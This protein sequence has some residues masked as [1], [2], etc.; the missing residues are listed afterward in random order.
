MGR[1]A[2]ARN[3]KSTK[4]VA[5]TAAMV[6][7]ATATGFAAGNNFKVSGGDGGGAKLECPRGMARLGQKF[8]VDASVF[9]GDPVPQITIVAT[10]AAD[11]FLV[12]K[13]NTGVHTGTHLDS[14]G[15][16]IEGGRTVD[17]LAAEEFVW[18]AYVVDVKARMAAVA[19]D[20]FQLS[21]ADI[22][23]YEKANGK[24]K[25]GSMVI[26]RTGFD[27]FY[28]TPAFLNDT[29]GFSAAAV[30][31]MVDNRN[32]GGVGSDTF[33]PDA[34]TDSTFGA[35]YTILNNNRVA[36]PGLNNL[37]ALQVKGDIMMAPTVA[38]KNGSGYQTDP[39][40]CLG[41]TNDGA[42]NHDGNDD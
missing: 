8:S 3:A 36:I 12:E 26:I 31:W 25:P 22:K 11:G 5:M 33:G 17:Q 14:P 1:I 42:S 2:R 23:A 7:I 19:D 20:G 29:P 10:I 40:A 16:F 34:S 27:K 21:V 39:L 35:T 24:I 32:I 41:R 18:P 6:A 9:P 28:G 13:V 38:L 4:V 15:H 37:D 30:Q